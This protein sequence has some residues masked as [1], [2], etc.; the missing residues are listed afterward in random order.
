MTSQQNTR[1]LYRQI[2]KAVR[3]Y[4][5]IR[6]EKIMQ[7]IRND[8]RANRNLEGEE[9]EKALWNAVMEQKRLA[10]WM[11]TRDPHNPKRLVNGDEFHLDL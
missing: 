6:R 10:R 1:I 11:T 8:F 7:G 5:S 3:Y 4:P 9:L 2:M